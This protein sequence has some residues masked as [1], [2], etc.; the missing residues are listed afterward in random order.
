V[1]IFLTID[2]NS[3]ELEEYLIALLNNPQINTVNRA[4]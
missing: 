1:N 2:S 3:K 4:C